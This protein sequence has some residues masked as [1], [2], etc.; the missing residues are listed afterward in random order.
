MAAG[1]SRAAKAALNQSLH[2]ANLGEFRRQIIY[3]FAMLGGR[4]TFVNPRHTSQ[5]CSRCGVITDC[6]SNETFTC[7]ACGFTEDRDLNAAINIRAR[8][9]ERPGVAASRTETINERGGE[10]SRQGQLIL[11]LTPMKREPGREEQTHV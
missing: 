9:L 1:T 8:S 4:L 5:I 2:D 6:G 10:V 11:A 7:A 3:K